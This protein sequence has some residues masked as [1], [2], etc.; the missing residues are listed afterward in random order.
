MHLV[1]SQSLHT[2]LLGQA[3]A[4]LS[5][6]V[7]RC[8]FT[9]VSTQSLT[10]LLCS[11][12]AVTSLLSR[13][14]LWQLLSALL[15]Q[16]FHCCLDTVSDDSSLLCWCSHFTAVS[17]NSS[18]LCW[19]SHFTAVSTQSLTTSVVTIAS[20]PVSIDYDRS[21]DKNRDVDSM[22]HGHVDWQFPDHCQ[23]MGTS[24]DHGS[25][26][27]SLILMVVNTNIPNSAWNSCFK[28]VNLQLYM[29]KFRQQ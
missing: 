4:I 11:V 24:R 26:L 17:D 21:F 2:A 18:L 15:M 5:F 19:C 10:T 27:I 25:T 12:D 20:E 22:L 9:A 7:W 29:D 16:S 13:H 3:T 8:H 28:V 14:S 1:S 6:Y 23:L